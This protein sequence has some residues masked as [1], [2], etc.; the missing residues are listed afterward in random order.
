MRENT[1]KS[2]DIYTALPENKKQSVDILF[3]LILGCWLL[4]LYFYGG[5]KSPG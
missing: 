5:I 3:I 4:L 1:G 2:A